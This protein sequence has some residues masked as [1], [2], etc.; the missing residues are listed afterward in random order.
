LVSGSSG[1]AV[2]LSHN[3]TRILIDCGISGRQAEACLCGI[4]A[5]PSAIDYILVTHEHTDHTQGVGVLSRRFDIPVVASRG[6]WNGMCI[7]G[8]AP[9][10][11]RIFDNNDQMD[12]GGIGV[13]PFDIPHDANQPTGY[14]FDA[15]GRRLAVATDI[16]H[17]SDG[18]RAAVSGCDTVLLEA[19]YDA[20]MLENGPYPYHLKNRIRGARGHLCNDD[21]GEF[22]LRLVRDGTKT[23]LL[24]HLSKENNSE[25]AAFATVANILER[26][27]IRVG[28]DVQMGVA[29]RYHASAVI[30][31]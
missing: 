8:I 3:G 11:V 25:R 15:G 22:A 6:T 30:G 7:G 2:F 23:L 16:G 17:I 1:N 28:T 12:I 19:N 21:A 26:G 14:R 5:E 29:P 13:T 10:N 31:L 18:V 27:G 20:D 9:K 4:G 24:G